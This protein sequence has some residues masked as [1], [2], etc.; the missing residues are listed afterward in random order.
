MI[1]LDDPRRAQRRSGF[2]KLSIHGAIKIHSIS[3]PYC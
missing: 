2:G 3:G 1:E